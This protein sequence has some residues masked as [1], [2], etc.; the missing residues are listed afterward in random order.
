MIRPARAPRFLPVSPGA[1]AASPGADVQRR[2]VTSPESWQE[3]CAVLAARLLARNLLWTSP[4]LTIGYGEIESAP[5]V[6]AV[7]HPDLEIVEIEVDR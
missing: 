6:R 5:S 2:T 4:I 7:W 1:W 3:L